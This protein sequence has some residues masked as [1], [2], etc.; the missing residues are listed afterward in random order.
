MSDD[1]TRQRNEIAATKHC[2]DA[3]CNVNDNVMLD[4]VIRMQPGQTRIDISDP[5]AW[6]SPTSAEVSRSS[7]NAATPR[8]SPE[9]WNPAMATGFESLRDHRIDATCFEP[10][11]FVLC[12]LSESVSRRAYSISSGC[13]EWRR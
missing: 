7:S 2:L 11:R 9:F 4:D 10:E 12:R 1:L 6:N 13:G 5:L 8:H 3:I